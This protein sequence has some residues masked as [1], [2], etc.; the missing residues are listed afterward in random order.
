V[1]LITWQVAAVV[2]DKPEKMDLDPV[3][4]EHQEQVVMEKRFLQPGQSH[5]AMVLLDLMVH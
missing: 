4:L 5:Q 3:D 1:V 2:L